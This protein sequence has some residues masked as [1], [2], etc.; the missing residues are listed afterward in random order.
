MVFLQLRLQSSSPKIS[1]MLI[2]TIAL[3]MQIFM[4][5]FCC[6]CLSDFEKFSWKDK[7]WW[8]AVSYMNETDEKLFKRYRKKTSW[9]NHHCFIPCVNQYYMHAL[10]ISSSV[11]LK[12]CT[13]VYFIVKF[14]CKLQWYNKLWTICQVF[15]KSSV[16]RLWY[17]DPKEKSRM[18]EPELRQNLNKK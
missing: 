9:H 7:T 14:S 6:S 15:L 11:N 8:K 17:C 18:M 13:N 1:M 12:V 16:I 4:F 2:K 10:C 3:S 5:K